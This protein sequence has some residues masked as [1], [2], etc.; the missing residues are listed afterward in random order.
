MSELDTKLT[1]TPEETPVTGE[2][3]L[4]DETAEESAAVE[5]VEAPETAALDAELDDD[6]GT[7]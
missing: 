1:Q 5:T 6:D 7:I 2:A 4:A 3:D